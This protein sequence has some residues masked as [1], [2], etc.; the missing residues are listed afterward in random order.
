[1][2]VDLASLVIKIDSSQTKEAVDNLNMLGKAGSAAEGSV[3]SAGKTWVKAS[4]EAGKLR[5]DAG[6]AAAELQKMT[7]QAE[8]LRARLDPASVA[9]SKMNKELA[10]AKVLF[11]RGVISAREYAR[12]QEMIGRSGDAVVKSAGAQRAGMQQLSYQL[13]DVATMFSMGAKPAQIFASQIGQVTQAV[14]LM[15]GGTSKLAAF[16]GGPWGMALSV[17]VV[18][19]SPFIGKLFE[20]GDAAD[21]AAASFKSAADE[22]RGLVGAMNSLALARRQIA[23]NEKRSRAME[24][25][26]AIGSRP[27]DAYGR[28]MFSWKDQQELE[29]LRWAMVE[30][31]N[32]IRLAEEAN[33]KLAKTKDRAAKSSERQVRSTRA[34]TK[35]M[36]DAAKAALEYAKALEA[37]DL[38]MRVGLSKSVDAL[39]K[40]FAKSTAGDMEKMLEGISEQS[41]RRTDAWTREAEAVAD[42]NDELY[43]LGDALS[44]L[45]GIGGGLGAFIGVL[46][47]L[48]TGTSS[49]LSGPGGFLLDE[50]FKVQF[51]DLEGDNKL[52]RLGD[53]FDESLQSVFG[54]NGSFKEIMKGAGFGIAGGQMFLGNQSA[55]GQLGSAIG[56]VLGKEAGAA[57]G[58]GIKGLAGKLA[59]PIGGI[60][61][62][63]LGG[64]VGGMFKKTK[65]ASATISGSGINITGN[66]SSREAAAGQLAGSVT[67]AI[68]EIAEA[69]GADIDMALGKVSVGIRKKSLR[70]DTTGAGRTKGAGVLDFGQD[71]EAA[72]KA[73]IADLISD[74]VLKGISAGMEKLLKGGD[75]EKQLEKA[76]K[77][78]GVFD[79][80]EQRTDPLAYAM[81][82]LGKEFDELSAIFA[83]AGAT[84]DEYAQLEQLRQL[85]IKEIQEQYSSEA[86]ALDLL[87]EKRQLEAEIMR[88][89]GNATGALTLLR[90]LEL[91]AMDA[92]LRPLQEQ[93][94]ALQDAAAKRELEI[95]LMEALGLAQEAEAARRAE[96]LKTIPDSLH[97]L[98]RQIWAAQ[99]ATKATEAYSTALSD[100]R[101]QLTAAYNREASALQQTADKFRGFADSLREFRNSLYG[102][103]SGMATLQSL[104]VALM[105]TG[106]LAAAGNADAM[107]ALPGVG[108]DYLSV[109]KGS[110]ATAQDYARSV[111]LVAGYTDK[112]I[113]SA[114]GKASSAEAQIAIMTKQYE[115]LAGIEEEQLSFNEAM[116][117]VK[118]LLENPVVPL[119][120]TPVALPED[121]VAASN[122]QQQAQ[123]DALNGINRDQNRR[124][125]D[126]NSA[127][128]E[129]NAAIRTMATNIASMAGII[130]RVERQGRFA[131][132]EEA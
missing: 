79:E 94:Y 58:E 121:Y 107:A 50:L 122:E 34:S 97:A 86:D 21:S 31:T 105:K 23:L 55:T 4:S 108:R 72:L 22:A 113:A 93:I 29:A 80:L 46:E 69:L 12:A 92:S 59:G 10:E 96:Y 112:A 26:L 18:A 42:Y 91:E 71:Q 125:D 98:Q 87:N 60:L 109:A 57:I 85:R 101:S 84:T 102:A 103:D 39:V 15:S 13:G 48:R 95:Q 90:Q 120:P 67:D 24:L 66:S 89:Q 128:I 82:Q 110:A 132:V 52:T 17:A 28:P 45:S 88:L 100:A 73:A 9:Q 25:E 81:K 1:M 104:T 43:R 65:K 53:I 68:N 7:K 16:L 74:G 38:A 20:S 36:D 40:D 123:I 77:F 131:T 127:M 30:E 14:Q 19:L 124:L 5:M 64:L 51:R 119:E 27:K 2:S 6:S 76:L 126:L 56:G 35:S 129:Q 115:K 75:I 118:E 41:S 37:A 130:K 70:V 49:G 33:D 83:E 106:G 3:N 8:A 114:A 111:A 116:Q 117:R 61:G 54:P 78:K 44:R 47:G 62:G 99:D 63:V 11:D 32:I